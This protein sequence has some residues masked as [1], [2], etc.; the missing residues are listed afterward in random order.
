[1]R[2]I[3]RVPKFLGL[4]GLT[5]AL[6]LG[7]ISR[8]AS[9]LPKD[10]SITGAPVEAAVRADEC[11]SDKPLNCS[12]G[13]CC[14]QGHTL[15]CPKSTCNDPFG[16]ALNNACINPNR[17]SDEQLAYAKNCCPVLASCN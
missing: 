14:A 9:T 15:H 7:Y 3:G 16:K 10:S 1:M 17:L 8:T 5:V 12:D 2:R 11:P 6:T 4:L 13:W